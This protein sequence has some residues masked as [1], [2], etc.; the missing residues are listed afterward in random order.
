MQVDFENIFEH[1]IPME[2]FRLNWRFTDV[3]FHKLSDHHLKLLQPLDIEASKYL[4]D[5]ISAT[6]LHQNTPF[7]KGFF[8]TI[9]KAKITSENKREVRKWLYQ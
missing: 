4:W 1:T 8:R 5:Y 2:D 6:N 7:K 3:L 9:D